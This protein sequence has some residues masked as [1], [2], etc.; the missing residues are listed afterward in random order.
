MNQNIT[1]LII[2][3]IFIIIG[4][5]NLLFSKK[6]KFISILP[7]GLGLFLIWLPTIGPLSHSKKHVNEIINIDSSKVAKIWVQPSSIPGNEN[8]SLVNSEVVIADRKAIN[9]LCFALHN[10]VVVDENFLKKPDAFCKV[11]IDLK[12]KR[13]IVFGMRFSGETASLEID[14]DGESGWHYAKLQG[15]KFGEIIRKACK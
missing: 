4:F 7:I 3:I 6:R 8:I 1:P 11:Q 15:N 10:A 13:N 14:S 5:C 9:E 2:G 12:D